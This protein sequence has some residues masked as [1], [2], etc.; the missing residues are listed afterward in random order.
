MIEHSSLG[1]NIT[2]S[3][4]YMICKW[5]NLFSFIDNKNEDTSKK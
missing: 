3:K 2:T 4:A 1:R 5:S